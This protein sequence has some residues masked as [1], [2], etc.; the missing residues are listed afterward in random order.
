MLGEPPATWKQNSPLSNHAFR[1]E[2]AQRHVDGPL[3]R[4]YGMQAVIREVNTSPLH[5][6]IDEK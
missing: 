4:A 5:I 6:L 2:F 3:V 1:L